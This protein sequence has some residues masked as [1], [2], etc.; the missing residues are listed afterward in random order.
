MTAEVQQNMRKLIVSE[1]VSLDGVYD[2][3]TM[4]QWFN[5]YD[6]EERQEYIRDNVLSSGAALL[7]RTTYEMLSGYWSA[8][9]NNEFGFADK[10]NAMPKYVVSTTLKSGDWGPT[11]VISDNVA[12]EIERLKGESGGDIIVFGSGSLVQ[13]LM[14]AGVIDEYRILVQPIVAGTGKR[15]YREDMPVTTLKLA[16]SKT[17]PLGVNLLCYEPAKVPAAVS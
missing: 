11:T 2:A 17:M 8:Q 1:W 6:S 15:F 3:D 12:K 7:G 5:P 9:K 14:D 4:D 10:L 13:S 16:S